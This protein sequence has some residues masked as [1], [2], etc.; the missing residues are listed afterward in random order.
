[1]ANSLVKESKTS[2]KAPRFVD[3]HRNGGRHP[4]TRFR[5][6]PF[7]KVIKKVE[8]RKKKKFP[9]LHTHKDKKLK[10]RKTKNVFRVVSLPPGTTV[11]TNLD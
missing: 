5:L 11:K 9:K 7:S 1:M 10:K 8:V 6:V 2:I 4:V 3:I